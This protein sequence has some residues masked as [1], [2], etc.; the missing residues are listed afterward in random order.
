M[1]ATET[2]RLA[3]GV[4][5]AAVVALGAAWAVPLMRPAARAAPVPKAAVFLIVEVTVS[6]MT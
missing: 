2:G 4:R 5:P 3:L 1:M 6:F